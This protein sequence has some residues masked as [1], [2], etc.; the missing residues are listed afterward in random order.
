M[1]TILLCAAAGVAVLGSAIYTARTI[2]RLLV[3]RRTDR[4]AARFDVSA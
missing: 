4:R 1:F 2:D 3:D